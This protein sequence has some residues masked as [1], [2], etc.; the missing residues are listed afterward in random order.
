[1]SKNIS[2]GIRVF[3]TE[4]YERLLGEARRARSGTRSDKVIAIDSLIGRLHSQLI[5]SRESLETSSPGTT[6][7]L[8]LDKLEKGE[9]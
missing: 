8:I 2:I 3:S 4:E 6:V 9:V 5:S 1:L 7:S